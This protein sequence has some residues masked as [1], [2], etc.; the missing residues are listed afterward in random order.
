MKRVF[1]AALLM[2]AF[3]TASFTREYVASGKTHS[4][5]G[6]YKIEI[7]DKPVT[8]NGE[9][10]KAFVISYQNTPLEVKVV[11]RKGEKCK[12]YLVLSNKLSVQY[13][14]NENYF[15]VQKLDKSLEIDGFTT[16]DASLNRSEY[17]HQKVIVPGKR[18]EIENAQLIAAYF[19]LL[20]NNNEEILAER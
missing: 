11:I 17:F 6:D 1:F 2:V 9:E 18:G 19:P 14:C 5:F 16:S 10:L 13:V 4:A 8:I 7:A 12:N 15:G 3:S 20:I